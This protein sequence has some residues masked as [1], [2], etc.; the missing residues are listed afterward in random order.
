MTLGQEDAREIKYE[1]RGTRYEVKELGATRL[2]RHGGRR[3]SRKDV[4]E[5]NP[6]TREVEVPIVRRADVTRMGIS[7]AAYLENSIG[8]GVTLSFLFVRARFG[9]WD[10]ACSVNK[11]GVQ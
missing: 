1:V 10:C 4:W 11:R 9:T 6:R 2:C 3:Q 8:T 5:P 7:I